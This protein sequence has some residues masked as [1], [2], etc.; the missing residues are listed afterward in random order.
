[1]G[2]YRNGHIDDLPWLTNAA[3]PLQGIAAYGTYAIKGMAGMQCAPR[4]AAL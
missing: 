3:M 2:A 1:M 4:G